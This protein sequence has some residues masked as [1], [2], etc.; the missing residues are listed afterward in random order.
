MLQIIRDRMSGP[1]VWGIIGFL[2]LLFAVWG[3]GAQSFLGGGSAPTLAKVG[4]T[5]ITQPEFQNAFNRSYQRLAQMAGNNFDPSQINLSA[6]REDVFNGLV[7]NAV[8]DQYA[9][10]KGYE[11]SDRELYEF[12][13]TIP[14]FQTNGSFSA[15]TYRYVLS[16]NGLA[17][18]TYEGH[19][20]NALRSEQLQ[21]AVMGTSFVVPKQTAMNWVILHQQRDFE[22]VIFDPITYRP[23]IHPSAKTIKA[24]YE[25]HKDH[26][27]E[28]EA[29]KLAYVELNQSDL[30]PT[31][32]PRKTVLKAIYDQQKNDRFRVAA[33]RKAS[34]ILIRFGND[35]KEAHRKIQSIASRIEKGASFSS[36]AKK[37]SQDPISSTKGGVVGWIKQGSDSSTFEKAV[38]S[39]KKIGQVSSP[40]KTSTGWHLIR[41]DEIRPEHTLPF[42]NPMVQHALIKTYDSRV[43]AK[44]FHND[45]KKLSELTFEHPGSLDPV[46]KALGLHIRSTGWITRDKASGIANHHDVLAAAFSKDVLQN[47]NNSKPI[48]IGPGDLVVIRKAELKPK[49]QLT[50][51]EVAGQIREKLIGENAVKEANKSAHFLMKAVQHGVPFKKACKTDNLTPSA[52]EAVT[53]SDEKL[54]SALVETAFRLPKPAKGQPS[55]GLSRLPGG[56]FAVIVLTAVHNASLKSANVKDPKYVA[57]GKQLNSNLENLEFDSYWNFMATQIGI[58]VKQAPGSATAPVPG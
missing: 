48:A 17:P 43:A 16:R 3:I 46:A 32:R 19:L 44:N 51:A 24:Y 41:L 18:A 22:S 49:K 54:P 26:Y 5:E 45:Q 1:L 8:I 28:P 38:F 37:Y 13:K 56:K 52:H 50:L 58:Q 15:K 35:P 14:A 7:R 4:S 55:V 29:I 40:I 57:L 6:L 36:L 42:K 25:K 47:G 20:R 27:F 30:S 12:L 39:L 11:V 31:K 23:Q 21:F 9:I 34:Q 53:R 2:V 10:K 33:E